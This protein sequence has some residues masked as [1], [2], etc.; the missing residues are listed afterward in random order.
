MGLLINDDL[1]R[2][3]TEAALDYLKVKSQNLPGCSE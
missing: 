2:T 3:P 1:K